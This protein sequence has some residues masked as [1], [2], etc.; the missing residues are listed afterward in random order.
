MA[1]SNKRNFKNNQTSYTINIK[2]YWKKNSIS[3]TLENFKKFWYTT[4]KRGK[5][6]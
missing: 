5:S 3:T 4:I 6:Q 1:S 2:G